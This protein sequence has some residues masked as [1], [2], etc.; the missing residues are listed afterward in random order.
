[1]F[2]L[3]TNIVI[4][5]FKGKFNM[6][7]CIEKAGKDNCFISEVTLAELFYG[8][9]KSASPA[10]HFLQIEAFL[11]EIRVIPITNSLRTYAAEKTNLEQS[12]MPLDDFDLLIAA[13]AEANGL[14]LV[15]NNTKH[16]SRISTLQ[17]V[18]WT[19]AQP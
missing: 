18:D 4:F 13:T 19:V 15:T 7:T 8:A 3:D 12:G 2:L 9:E 17:L 5:F 16:F 1:M 6:L 11:R 10:K 14:V